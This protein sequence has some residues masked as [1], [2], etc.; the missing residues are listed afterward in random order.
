MIVFSGGKGPAIFGGKAFVYDRGLRMPMMVRC[1]EHF[2]P[3]L[4]PG[5]VIDDLVSATDIGPTLI[6]FAGSSVP[7][8]TYGRLFFGPNRQPEPEYSLAIRDRCNSNLIDQIRSVRSRWYKYIKNFMPKKTYYEVSHNNIAAHPAG[9]KLYEDGLLPPN[10]A[11]FYAPKPVE[12]LCDTSTASYE[13]KNLAGD[14]QHKKTS[15]AMRRA[16]ETRKAETNETG[17]RKPRRCW[18][19]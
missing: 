12:E 5:D 6:D 10:Q 8:Y 15:V 1:P 9:H 16:L 2:H 19:K 7:D 4:Q 13:M 3:G 14:P 11:A 17:G 18:R